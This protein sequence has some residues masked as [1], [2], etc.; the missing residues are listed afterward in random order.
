MQ[1]LL[2]SVSRELLGPGWRVY[3]CRRKL[4]PG[5]GGGPEI[6]YSD[7]RQRARYRLLQVCASRWV[8]PVCAPNILSRVREEISQGLGGRDYNLYLVTATI[9]HKDGDPLAKLLEDLNEGWRYARGGPVWGKRYLLR[10]E[11]HVG[12]ITALEIRYGGN[13][14]HP[15]KHSLYITEDEVDPADLKQAYTRYVKYLQRNGYEVNER[16]LDVRAVKLTDYLTKI[17]LELTLG[18]DKVGRSD[19]SL[20]PFQML[21]A[22]RQGEKRYEP[23][24]REYAEA[25][26]G[27]SLIRFSRGL[28]EKLGLGE[29]DQKAAAGDVRPEDY[30]LARLTR[31]DWRL[32]LAG[33]LRGQLLEVAN[34]GDPERIEAFLRELR[35]S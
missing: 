18:P 9:Q 21:D 7:E 26:R 8:C 34:S 24:F 3:D 13:G 2:Q 23:L 22:I 4:I 1:F 17:A 30:L 25:T 31:E 29:F 28:R 15:H 27:K 35:S 11:N 14:W 10:S 33:E 16:T 19:L 32:V 20:S 5:V 6:V 12:T